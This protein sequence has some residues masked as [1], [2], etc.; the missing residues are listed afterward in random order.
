MQHHF[1]PSILREYDIRGTVGR[2]LGPEDARAVGQ[3][4]GSIVRRG[5][6]R[7]VAVGRDGR[8]SSPALEAALIEGLVAA[9]IEVVRIGLGP[10]PM[11]YHAERS[12]KV[13]GGIHV[14]GSHNPADDNGFKIV[15]GHRPFFGADIT[16][17]AALVA[18]GDVES[19]TGQVTEANV[20]ADYVA[21]LVEGPPLPPFR[22][23][24][25]AGNGA[26]GP[27]VERLVQLLPGEHHLLFTD[28]DGDFPNHHP[29]PTEEANL[30]HLRTLVAEESLNF[31]VAFD[32]DGDRIGA[33]DAHGRVVAGDQLLAILAEP[34][35]RA[36]PGAAIVADVK[37]SATLFDRIAELGGRPV[38]W[39]SG[40]SN[41]KTMM[42]E[43][44]APLAGEMSGHLF[45][46]ELGG[47]DDALYAAVQ[48]IRAVGASGGSLADLRDAMPDVVATPELRFAVDEPRKTAVVEEVLAR[49]TAEGA[50]VDRTDG[51]RVTTADGWW[52]LR[53]S[54]TQAMLT[55][56]AE[57][58][59]PAALDRLV[60][61]IDAQLAA[62]GVVRAR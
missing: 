55:A 21:R 13:D 19:G 10:S 47:H 42:H 46:A 40:H 7:Q 16:A 58:R 44:G 25:D 43:V 9:G 31:G 33:I 14:T 37:A 54:N 11:L 17:L 36:Q 27:A 5:G 32:G 34:A 22:I 6:G 20:L 29:D 8:R 51:A 2:T 30:A 41:I 62:S 15:L 48:L 35:L 49:L 57:A 4:F 38:M 3:G 18:R 45:F 26:A 59:D 56:R 12:L 23:G 50:S 28:V 61:T 52:L 39:K 60:E 53:A 24:W 1:H